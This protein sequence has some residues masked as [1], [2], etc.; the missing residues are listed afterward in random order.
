MTYRSLGHSF[1]GY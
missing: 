1:F